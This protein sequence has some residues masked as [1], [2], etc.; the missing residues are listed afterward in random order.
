MMTGEAYVFHVWQ[1]H[2]L[3]LMYARFSDETTSGV[4]YVLLYTT[5]SDR[6]SYCDKLFNLVTYVSPSMLLL[7]QWH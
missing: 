1:T 2:I 6:T 7:R 3:L 4:T 5:G